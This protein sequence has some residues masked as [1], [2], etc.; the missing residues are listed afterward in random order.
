M[1][2]SRAV[3]LGNDS[4]KDVLLTM[5]KRVI[6]F[7]N[8]T[9]SLERENLKME[10]TGWAIV[11]VGNRLGTHRI[12]WVWLFKIWSIKWLIIDQVNNGPTH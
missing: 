1:V 10:I 8:L 6:F 5:E 2:G 3:L 7:F 4:E 11:G 12:K 9:S